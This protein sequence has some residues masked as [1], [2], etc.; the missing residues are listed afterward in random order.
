[1]VFIIFMMLIATSVTSHAHPMWGIAVDGTGQVY[2]TDLT[3]VWRIDTSGKLSV[4]R[5][6]GD[7]HVHEISLDSDGNLLGAENTYV[8]ATKKFFSAI[9]KMTPAGQS[10]YVVPLQET[11][12]KATSIWRDGEGNAHYVTEFPAGKLL[13]LKWAPSGNVVP[14]VG[15]ARAARDFRQS[16]PYGIS[17][18]VFGADGALYFNHRASVNKLTHDGRLIKITG[19]IPREAAPGKRELTSLYGIAID[20]QGNP[21]VADYGNR[22]VFRIASADMRVTTIMRADGPWYPT[23][24]AT[25]GEDIY[26]LEA[27]H[28]PSHEPVGTRVRKL[29]A[30]GGVTVLATV[31]PN[32]SVNA[33]TGATSEVV[34]SDPRMEVL[35]TAKEPARIPFY[36]LLAIGAA[37]GIIS[38]VVWRKTRTG[39]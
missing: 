39:T 6:K 11:P 2:F 29:S 24:V 31:D 36:L 30:D 28:T 26:V 7:G 35:P 21:V 34:N 16:V 14:L 4:F 38:I 37:L 12:P 13:L 17:P 19:N 9:W 23:G 27:G 18:V 25:R 5:P 15:D 22:R 10:S 1:L 20:A 8:P 3:T 32:S 33:A